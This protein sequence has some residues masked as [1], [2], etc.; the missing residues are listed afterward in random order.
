MK[1]FLYALATDQKVMKNLMGRDIWLDILAKDDRNVKK[2]LLRM[3][4]K[5]GWKDINYCIN[6][7][8]K[9]MKSSNLR[10]SKENQYQVNE[11]QHEK[12]QALSAVKEKLVRNK[13]VF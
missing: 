5:T 9:E 3:A 13:D 10:N 1:V 4:I 11:S 7:Y 6:D 2:E 8:K 12:E